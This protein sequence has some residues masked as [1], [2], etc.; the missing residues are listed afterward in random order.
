MHLVRSGAFRFSWLIPVPDL[1]ETVPDPRENPFDAG[2][3]VP[4]SAL[5][6]ASGVTYVTPGGEDYAQRGTAFRGE[7]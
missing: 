2:G 6:S 1:G 7:S 4:R 3:G 5:Y